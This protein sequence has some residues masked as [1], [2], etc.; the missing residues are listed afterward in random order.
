LHSEYVVGGGEQADTDEILVRVIARLFH[1][2]AHG[3]LSY[4]AEKQG[5]AVRC[6]LRHLCGADGSSRTG[7]VVHDELLPEAL[8]EL[9][10]DEPRDET[11]TAAW[12]CRNHD[13]HRSGRIRLRECPC[14]DE[15]ECQRQ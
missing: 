2:R 5:M 4:E 3:E 13:T 7:T 8:A 9:L 11:V 15:H 10:T 14:R 6:C 1:M 12:R